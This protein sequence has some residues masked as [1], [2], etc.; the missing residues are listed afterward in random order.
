M[1]DAFRPAEIV[2]PVPTDEQ[3]PKLYGAAVFLLGM[4]ALA[5]VG[6]VCALALRGAPV[7]DGLI[8]IGAAAVSG[9]VGLLTPRN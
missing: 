9:L 6:V 5:V 8:A 1:D 7:S 3:A 2:S 4:V